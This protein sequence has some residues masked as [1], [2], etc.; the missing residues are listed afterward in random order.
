[1]LKLHVLQAAFGDC[2]IVELGTPAQR[3]YILIDGGPDLI[4]SRHLKGELQKITASGG[5][6]DIAVL[7]H[8][9]SDHVIGLLD[10]MAELRQQASSPNKTVTISELWHNCFS[11]AVGSG[12]NIGVRMS[13]LVAS[14]G[15]ASRGLASGSAVVQSIAEGDQLRREATLL[16]IPINPAFTDKVV[17][18][19]NSAAERVIEGVSVR[20]VGP[21]QEILDQLKA[22]WQD[23]LTK[24]AAGISSGDPLLA[25]YADKRIPN[26]SSI[27]LFIKDKGKT[28]LLT[29]DARGDHLLTG[30]GKAGLLDSK[31]RLRVD[32]LKLPHHGSDNN[33]TRTFFKT[34]TAGMY[35]I[36]A[37]GTNKNPDLATCIW[38]VEAARQQHR[39]IN[40]VAT[41][42]TP[43]L[44]QLQSDYPPA[45]YG[46]TLTIMPQTQ[47]AA[48]IELVAD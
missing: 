27:S 48:T 4:Y 1:M 36:S 2:L 18:V 34:V 37:D 42:E 9:D 5:K 3:K 30:L 12:N 46:Y 19:E 32:V 33:V 40:I 26:L 28:M 25:A 29:G 16:S 7:T 41:N 15:A 39:K 35:V 21:T 10:L 43:S 13:A 31:G 47:H 23:W 8:V 11:Q 44:L 38:L 20:V 45:S 6:V 17:M 14:A 22:Q 24:H